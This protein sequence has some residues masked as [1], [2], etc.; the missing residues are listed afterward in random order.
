VGKM[1]GGEWG[2]DVVFLKNSWVASS[3]AGRT[4]FVNGLELNWEARLRMR[5][6]GN[7]GTGIPCAD[8]LHTL[9]S[10][11]K[12]PHNN[13]ETETRGQRVLGWVGTSA[14]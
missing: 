11:H 10:H 4:S 3:R 7:E 8:I 9:T 6:S 14:V 12:I 2:G 13:Q 5:S 1:V